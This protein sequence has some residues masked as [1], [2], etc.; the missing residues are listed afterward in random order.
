MANPKVLFA[1]AIRFI[2]GQIMGSANHNNPSNDVV[3]SEKAI[4][5]AETYSSGEVKTNKRWVDGKPIYRKCFDI[6]PVSQNSSYAH[7]ITSFENL[8]S[9]SGSSKRSSDGQ[10][11]ALP[12]TYTNWEIYIYDVNVN[13][14]RLRYSDNQ[15]NN[16]GTKRAVVIL[17]YTKTTD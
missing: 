8:V 14:F 13:D 4:L 9:I 11:Q 5:D 6:T 17:E 10:I 3:L 2:K 16:T 1:N 15:W 7:S 12:G